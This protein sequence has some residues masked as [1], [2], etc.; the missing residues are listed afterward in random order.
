MHYLDI[1]NISLSLS[2]SLYV[3]CH[4]RKTSGT[5]KT[6]PMQ[7]GIRRV[8]RQAQKEEL[9][10][11]QRFA[12]GTL[13]LE[14]Q[15]SDNGQDMA[16]KQTALIKY[17][18][19]GLGHNELKGAHLL[20]VCHYIYETVVGSG[21]RQWGTLLAR[22]LTKNVQR[23]MTFQGVRMWPSDVYVVGKV[24]EL[25]GREGAGFCLGLDDTGI[26]KSGILSL[27]GLGNIVTYRYVYCSTWQ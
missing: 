25:V 11:V 10:L 20:E 18:E 15:C 2:L 16:S 27:L 9:D 14:T 17:L 12:I 5:L 6:F 19:K 7:A 13:F 23:E 8:R 22:V 1:G 26:Q 4:L 24:L 3:L 21:D